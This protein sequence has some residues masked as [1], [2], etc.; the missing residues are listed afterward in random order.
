MS[1]P[2]VACYFNSRKRSAAEDS[3]VNRVKKVL[4]LDSDQIP[5]KSHVTKNLNENLDHDVQSV[6]SSTVNA[7]V[8]NHKD[9]K[10]L[11]KNKVFTISNTKPQGNSKSSTAK[12]FKIKNV[13][14][15]SS[16]S[17]QNLQKLI[18]NMRN[19]VEIELPQSTIIQESEPQLHCT[20]PSTP[21]K[22]TNALD[23]IKDKPDGPSIKEI[24]KKMT[25]SARLAELKASINRFQ[26]G[27]VK[28]KELEKETRKIEESPKLKSFRTIEL[29][30][31]TR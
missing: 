10:A 16:P 13:K 5:Q 4:V 17:S 23:K 30:V 31:C 20:P 15:T 21:T 22:I 18:Q 11:F 24:R 1:Q 7:C 9:E 14:P 3:K 19:K 6:I 28:L 29:E 25:R 27:D 2:S 8:S 12:C 26:E